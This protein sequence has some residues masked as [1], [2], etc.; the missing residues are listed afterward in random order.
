MFIALVSASF[1]GTVQVEHFFYINLLL[2]FFYDNLFYFSEETGLPCHQFQIAVVNFDVNKYQIVKSMVEYTG[3][4]VVDE[5]S[6]STNIVVSL[7]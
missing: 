4:R 7:T 6:P 3:A 5:V 1:P 2:Y